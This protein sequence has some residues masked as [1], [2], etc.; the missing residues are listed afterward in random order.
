MSRAQLPAT[1]AAELVDMLA[2]IRDWLADSGLLDESLHRF[3]GID[4]PLGHRIGETPTNA[5]SGVERLCG[6]TYVR[7]D[8]FDPTRVGSRSGDPLVGT[9]GPLI[10]SAMI[11]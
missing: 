1:D 7:A 3:M 8:V 2:V 4:A 10:E 5:V 11:T 9:K 6:E